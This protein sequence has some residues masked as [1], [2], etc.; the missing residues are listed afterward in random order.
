MRW[1]YVDRYH[2][3]YHHLWAMNPDGTRQMVLYGNQIDS[4]VILAPKPIP[5]SRYLVARSWK[6]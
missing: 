5:N 3:G 1:E 4:G 2:L 6:T